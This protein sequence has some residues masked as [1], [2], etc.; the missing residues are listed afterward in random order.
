MH[1]LLPSTHNHLRPIPFGIAASSQSSTTLSSPLCF[2]IAPQHAWNPKF[3]RHRSASTA[4]YLAE[5]SRPLLYWPEVLQIVIRH[6]CFEYSVDLELF[7][8]L[9]RSFVKF[10]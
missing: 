5:L 9:L 4:V 10:Y 3:R 2:I 7:D 8:V 1:K 6:L